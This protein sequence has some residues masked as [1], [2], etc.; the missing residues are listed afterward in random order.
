M[1]VIRGVVG[2]LIGGDFLSKF[3]GLETVHGVMVGT[4][5]SAL[6][7]ILE[8]FRWIDCMRDEVVRTT[9]H[10][11]KRCMSTSCAYFTM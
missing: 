8:P 3:A 1:A 2:F 11:I 4:P 9:G 6:D 7:W 5:R 10:G